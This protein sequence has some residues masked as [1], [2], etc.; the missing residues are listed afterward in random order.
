[1]VELVTVE[2]GEALDAVRALFAEYAASLGVDLGFQHFAAELAGLMK[3]VLRGLDAVL[4]EPAYN[5]FL[6]TAPLRSAELAYYHWHLEMT[7]RTSR[8]AGF[9]W[10]AGCFITTVTPEQAA[11]EL[12]AALA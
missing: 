8:P 7:P 12:R 2:V 5:W 11:M 6:H 1:M 10:G 9:E 3:R 4:A